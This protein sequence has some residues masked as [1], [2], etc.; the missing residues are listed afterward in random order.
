MSR[1]G[2][3]LI[4]ITDEIPFEIPNNWVWTRLSNVANIYTGNSISETEKRQNILM[5]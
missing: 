3:N 4:D 1:Y 2:K 5:S